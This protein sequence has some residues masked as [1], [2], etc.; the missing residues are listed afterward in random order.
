MAWDSSRTQFG[1]LEQFTYLA[2]SKYVEYRTDK[3]ATFSKGCH[4]AS[5][6]FDAQRLCVELNLF[7]TK[8]SVLEMR[9]SSAAFLM[10]PSQSP[11]LELLEGA[12]GSVHLGYKGHM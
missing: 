1:T 11:A 10:R 9:L 12:E 3:V 8:I 6:H 5:L 4:L 7:S 2:G